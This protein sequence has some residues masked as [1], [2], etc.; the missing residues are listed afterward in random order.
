MYELINANG[1][2]FYLDCP[3]KIG[4]VKLNDTDVCLIDSGNNKDAGKKALKIIESNNWKLTAVYNTHSHADHI[5]GN[6]YLQN[7][8]GCKI[9]AKGIEADFTNHPILEPAFLYGAFPFSEL[10]HKFLLANESDSEPLSDS[11]LPEGFEVLK[12]PGHSF[13]MVGFKTSDDVIYLADALSSEETLDKYKIS[14]IYDVGEYL[15]TLKYIKT[16]KAKLFIP[17]HTQATNDISELAQYNIDSVHSIAEKICTLCEEPL[18]FE[19]LLKKLFDEY[20]LTMTYQQ[21]A[22]IGS[23][24]RSYL[25]WLK[26]NAR[27]SAKIENNTFLW[28][29]IQ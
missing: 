4:L 14:F 29:K 9:Y 13:D 10:K 27:I 5:G 22:L 16:L 8:T 25:S 21:Y 12:L 2:S 24:V 11:V 18:T 20:A 17:S 1:N 23:T 19:E 6:K 15:N 3:S 26:D 28:E 7:A